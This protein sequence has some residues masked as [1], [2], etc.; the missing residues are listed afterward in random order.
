MLLLSPSSLIPRN[1]HGRVWSLITTTC[2]RLITLLSCVEPDENQEIK[3]VVTAANY[4]QITSLFICAWRSFRMK[5]RRRATGDDQVVEAAT[6]C[7]PP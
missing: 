5:Y 1:M 3:N 6:Y 7:L 4:L 2:R